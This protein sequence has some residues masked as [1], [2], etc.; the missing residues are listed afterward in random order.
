M[1]VEGRRHCSGV[2][3]MYRLY[4]GAEMMALAQREEKYIHHA[5]FGLQQNKHLPP[6]ST[7]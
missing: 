7:L 5:R 2:I 1:A 4:S 3:L 6:T